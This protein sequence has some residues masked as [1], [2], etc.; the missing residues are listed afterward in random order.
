MTTLSE[1]LAKRRREEEGAQPLEV[2]PEEAQPTD[3]LDEQVEQ[4]L[5]RPS[6]PKAER[7]PTG[8]QALAAVAAK[9]PQSVVRAPDPVLVK[10]KGDIHVELVNRFAGQLD[11][12][13]RHEVRQTVQT[14][15]DEFLRAEERVIN[16]RERDTLIDSLLDDVL[17][18]GP[19]EILLRDTN[20][21]EVMI[22][23]Y[24]KVYIE[25]ASGEIVDSPVVFDSE[26]QLRQVIDRIVSRMGRRVDESQP[27]VDARLPDGSRVNVVLPPVVTKG[28][29]MSIRKFVHQRMSV[30][31]MLRL[32]SATQQMMD[33]IAAAVKTRLTIMV[34]G[35]T[36]S[37]KTTL[38]NSISAFIPGDERIVT[39]EEAAELQLGQENVIG[40]E[41]RPP[42]MEGQ[43][44]ITIREL[45]RN[46]LRMRPD[47]VIVGE[48]RGPEAI[49]MLQAMNTGHEG[50][51]STIHSNSP[52]DVVS[53]LETLILMGGVELPQKAIT[54]Q[55]ASALDIIVQVER[56]RGGA[57]RIVSMTEVL[58]LD[59]R[60]EIRFQE[61]F[62]YRQVGVNDAGATRGYHTATGVKSAFLEH[63][64]TR[65]AR[66][67]ESI[68]EPAP[69]PPWEELY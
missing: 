19:L 58:G 45:V 7:E 60:G 28:A 47:R 22:N 63:F 38:L 16:P 46:A 26:R 56:V 35:G 50:S 33:Y 44:E 15:V 1:R 32:R 8:L 57:R 34:S 20:I 43:G 6:A 29:T 64:A 41:H 27:M 30:E 48:T 21:N 51:L 37:G 25:L 36:S 9:Q 18:L 69:E 17:G 11:L 66:L 42:N 12:S 4:P 59:D 3:E 55:I 62:Q 39:I 2:V 49:D 23:N 40:M 54:K 5:E 61:V 13:D 10:M 24:R 65:G 14:L 53:R 52:E 68:F 31:D 67:D